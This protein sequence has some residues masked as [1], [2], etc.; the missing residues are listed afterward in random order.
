MN[1][2]ENGWFSE[3][4]TLWPGQ[5]FSLEVEEVLFHGKSK[6]QEILVFKSKT[7]GNVLA[8]DGVIQAT[9]RDE[10]A[11]QEMLTQLPMHAHPNP[12]NILVIGGGDGGV[13]RE[14]CKHKCVK[15]VTICEIDKMVIEKSK[16]FLPQLGKGFDDDRVVVH[17]GDGNAFVKSKTNEF[18]V[19]IVDSS[20]PVGPAESLY[21]Q[22]FYQSMA[23]ALNPGGIVCTQAECLW[24]HLDLIKSLLD[25][26]SNIFKHSEYAYTTIPTYPCGQIGF[27]LGSLGNSCK[28]PVRKIEA[29]MKYY[30]EDIHRASFVLPQYARNHLGLN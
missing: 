6:Y 9:E 20:D 29:E 25:F 7:Y 5:A 11:Y 3:F 12:E 17:Y 26:S 23:K 10:F 28:S 1:K 22:E 14:V 19:I 8:L 13:L 21:K 27:L 16:E 24:L 18:D 2:I 30:N 4:S 15:K